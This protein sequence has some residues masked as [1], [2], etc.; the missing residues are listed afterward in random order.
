[1][2]NPEQK[3]VVVSPEE[4]APIKKVKK[5]GAQRQAEYK[6]RQKEKEDK[7]AH[8][9]NSQTEPS[10]KEAYKILA[11]RGILNQRVIETC[12]ELALVAAEELKI[13]ANAFLF[14]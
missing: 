6:L 3:G 7:I 2:E 5:S 14:R 8:I 13:P 4:T 1:M 11:D 10:K 9:Y 12:H